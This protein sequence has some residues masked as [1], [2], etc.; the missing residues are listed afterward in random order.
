MIGIQ[1]RARGIAASKVVPGGRSNT[2]F[3]RNFACLRR[4]S[5][6][7]DR[8]EIFSNEFFLFPSLWERRS[9]SIYRRDSQPPLAW[10]SPFIKSFIGTGQW[11]HFDRLSIYSHSNFEPDALP[12]ASIIA[13]E[14]ELVV[15]WLCSLHLNAASVLSRYLIC[16]PCKIACHMSLTLPS[17]PCMY[18]FVFVRQKLKLNCEKACEWEFPTKFSL[19]DSSSAVTTTSTSTTNYLQAFLHFPIQF[20]RYSLFI[21]SFPFNT[22][23]KIFLNHIAQLLI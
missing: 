19:I 5:F 21:Q 4:E 23:A 18:M 1:L 13:S 3:H 20:E 9:L 6:A 12:E 11:E 14:H 16:Y 8:S 15:D 7:W 22:A 10:S 17:L 2:T